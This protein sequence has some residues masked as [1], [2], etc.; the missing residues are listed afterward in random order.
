ERHMATDST[1]DDG[2]PICEAR[3]VSV[4]VAEGD[5]R[6]AVVI[7]G[8]SLAVRQGEVVAVLG[9]SGCGKSTLMRVMTGLLKPT[10]G[11]VLA[12]G[13]PLSGIQPGVGL[14]FQGFALFPWLTVRQNVEV[15]VN[16]LG[17]SP[18]AAAARV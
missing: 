10:A 11:R 7:D 3:D 14:V 1:P 6:P 9:P 4:S 5:G 13:G 17:M 15:G 8:V 18:A 16:G 2:P 12:H